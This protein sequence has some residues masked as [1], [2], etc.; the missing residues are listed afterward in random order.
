MKGLRFVGSMT[1]QLTCRD[2]VQTLE[3]WIK[4]SQKHLYTPQERPDLL[5][6]GTGDNSWGVQT[7]QK[8]FAAYAVLA[9]EPMY[10]RESVGFDQ[11]YVLDCALRMLRFSL[12]SHVEGS[13]HCT[14]LTK[15][16][17]TWISALGLERLFHGIEAIEPHLTTWDQDLLRKVVL[18]ECG[19]L[20]DHYEVVAGLTGG[21]NKPESNLWN[22]AI[23][24]RAAMMYPDAPRVKEYQEKGNVFLMNSISVESD[25][26]DETV[27]EGRSVQ[28]WHIGSNFFPTYALNHHGYL[29]VGYMVIC[30]SNIAMLHFSYK[31]RQLEAPLSLYHHAEDLWKI[32]KKMIFPDGRLLRIGGDTRVPYCYCQDYAIP[33]WLF[34]AEMYR[35]AEAVVF[36]KAWLDQVMR[37]MQHNG[38]GTYLSDRCRELEPLSPLYYARLESDRAATLSMGAYWRR[39][40]VDE[41]PSEVDTGGPSAVASSTTDAWQDE[42]HGACMH[43]SDTR[44][45]SFVWQAGEKPQGLCLPPSASD[46]AEWR[47]NLAGLIEGMGSL[48]ERS[49]VSH[50]ESMFEGG[51]LTY[52][53]MKVKT[54]QFLAEGQ[55]S[56]VVA[57]HHVVY[58]ALPDDRTVLVMQYADTPQRSFIRTLRGLLLQMPN[59][60][61]NANVRRYYTEN[62]AMELQGVGSSQ[63]LRRLNS[64]WLNVDGK[65]SVIHAYGSEGLAIH[66]PG[67]RQIGLKRYPGRSY[68]DELGML[69]AD[70]I[71]TEF[72]DE[73]TGFTPGSVLLDSG[74]VLQSGVDH[75]Y[76][77]QW[78]ERDNVEQYGIQVHSPG[79]EVRSMAARGADGHM[80]VLLAQF[81]DSAVEVIVEM[82]A[83]GSLRELASGVRM[84]GGSEVKLQPKQA[85][86]FVVVETEAG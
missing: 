11:D 71:V 49:V 83:D 47:W 16:G 64:R 41:I 12:E 40:F 6:Y 63:E 8:A 43:Q 50:T 73:L 26:Q 51:F 36:E 70:E 4:G 19:W 62:G 56:H 18:S 38:D 32:V 65:L 44:V 20:M 69:Y 46:M 27:V 60:L 68:S 1:M 17:H 72:V 7:N 3:P 39:A 79:A 33:M 85:R 31:R 77:Q 52:G 14:D 45:A 59:D 42:Y 81:G 15:W 21:S 22:G 48:N 10:D 75:V 84:T 78:V 34:V 5:C 57:H 23:L 37:E 80:Y 9:A 66:R 74:A 13:Y 2:Y 82:P 55:P 29:N 54:D 61:F 76:T 25:A 35:D 24:H 67:Y 30:L 53:S 86:L 58:A 28:D